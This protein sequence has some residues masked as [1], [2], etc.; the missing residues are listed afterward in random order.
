[1]ILYFLNVQPI[2][3]FEISDHIHT[4]VHGH[5]NHM[6]DISK[7]DTRLLLF[8]ELLN[9][10]FLLIIA[11]DLILW[12]GFKMVSFDVKELFSFRLQIIQCDISKTS[13]NQALT[14]LCEP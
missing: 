9:S 1:M 4:L 5:E 2:V 13:I 10:D 8:F 11:N 3:L 6:I 12:E 7:P 14:V